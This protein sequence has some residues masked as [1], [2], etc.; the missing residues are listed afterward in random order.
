MLQL[1]GASSDIGI[2]NGSSSV[3]QILP[4]GDSITFGVGSADLNSYRES[5]QLRLADD[6]IDVEFVGSVRSGSILNNACEAR[7][8]ATI[9]QISGLA[10]QF[11]ASL[12]STSSAFPQ[13]VT[14]LAGT[15]DIARNIDLA[16]SPARIITLIG[17]IQAASPNTAVLVG[18]IPPL[19][20][21][22]QKLAV[23][24]GFNQA[25]QQVVQNAAAAGARVGFVDLSV[26]GVNDLADGVHP[27]AGGYIKMGQ[28]W[29]VGLLQAVQQGVI[30][31]QSLQ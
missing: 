3:L 6:G 12:N 15:N 25:I 14:L 17:K 13:V 7:P 1:P 28:A 30:P 22:G 8:G 11:L 31:L 10:D 26:V 4:L 18:S 2:N 20:L 9:D 24:D 16:N 27:N 19:V 29:V 5:L 21:R 23:V